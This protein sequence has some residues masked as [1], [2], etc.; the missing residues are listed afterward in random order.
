M[1][2]GFTETPGVK[3]FCAWVEAI[4]APCTIRKGICSRGCNSSSF[5]RSKSYPTSRLILAHKSPEFIIT[6]C[7]W[8]IQV[9]CHSEASGRVPNNHRFLFKRKAIPVINHTSLAP[10]EAEMLHAP[11]RVTDHFLPGTIRERL[12]GLAGDLVDPLT[13]HFCRLEIEYLTMR[14]WPQRI[15]WLPTQYA[16]LQPR[17][18]CKIPGQINKPEERFGHRA[19][20]GRIMGISVISNIHQFLNCS[21]PMYERYWTGNRLW[22][23]KT[24]VGKMALYMI[25]SGKKVAR[26][27][28]RMNLQNDSSTVF[29]M[30]TENRPLAHSI[31][32]AFGNGRAR[33]N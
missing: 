23:R 26:L 7:Q 6:R 12:P 9:P 31:K 10:L 18:T 15:T 17:H 21:M 33:H 4:L 11:I 2:K 1:C 25:N 16:G 32:Q 29:Q 30:E 22:T 28:R 27:F 3:I 20:Y 5:S 13:S 8:H 24:M 19:A 14:R